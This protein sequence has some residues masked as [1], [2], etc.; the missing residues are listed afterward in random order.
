MDPAIVL[1]AGANRSCQNG[2]FWGSQDTV[3]IVMPLR[4]GKFAQAA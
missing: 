4:E 2:K 1:L 3:E